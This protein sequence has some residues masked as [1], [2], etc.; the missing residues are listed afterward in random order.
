MDRLSGS[1]Q[2]IHSRLYRTT[3]SD[4]RLDGCV[5]FVKLVPFR[6]GLAGALFGPLFSTTNQSLVRTELLKTGPLDTTKGTITIP[7]IR[8]T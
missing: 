4:L 8:D 5:V 3:N 7:R 2:D 6:L 1:V